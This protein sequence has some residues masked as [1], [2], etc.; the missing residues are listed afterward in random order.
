M[1][2]K[3][4]N[5]LLTVLALLLCSAYLAATRE[6]RKYPV[7]GREM[8]ANVTSLEDHRDALAHW[9]GKG[10]RNAVLM[11]IDAHDDM[12]KIP[13]WQMAHVKLACRQQE[14]ASGAT[15]KP[16][17]PLANGN[18]IHAAAKMGIIK[19]VIW[20]VPSSYDLFSDPANRLQGLLTSYGFSDEDIGTF[21]LGKGSFSG[22]VDGIPL[23]ICDS[24]SLP[25]LKEPILLSID[26]DFFP[27]MLDDYKL[28]ITD[29]LKQTFSDLSG[30]GYA[31]MDATVAYSVN[32][33][34][35]DSCRRWVG[36]LIIDAVRIPSLLSRPRLPERYVFLQRT[37]LL[38][39]MKRYRELLMKLPEVPPGE[40][41]PALLLYGAKAYQGMAKLDKA[42]H[43][44]EMACLRDNRYCGGLPEL[45]L[46][47]LEKGEISQAERFF[48]RGYE[49][50]P[51]MDNGQ[52]RLAMAL[53][54]AGRY[55]KA[56]DYFRVFRKCYGPFPVDFYLA[57]TCMLKGD[58]I[59]ARKYYDSGRE[60]L[61]GNPSAL[62]G[63][64][65]MATLAK[66]A[67]FYD[68]KEETKYALQ[69]RQL[70]QAK[71]GKESFS[72]EPLLY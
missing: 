40:T 38:M 22:T 68:S 69:I 11:N 46:S 10:F 25:D 28:T 23:A 49:L 53:K 32:G 45:G 41:D 3:I 42:F 6:Y 9:Y 60:E 7:L 54:K 31:I 43:Y 4:A 37:D 36:E 19:R 65:D 47:I 13:P 57:E 29:A 39:Q 64:G 62:N 58:D 61:V 59:S 56:I 51:E 15:R 72:T 55:D 33:G 34:Y 12:K 27:T 14:G 52:F 5:I 20:V 71:A 66:G 50:S 1:R 48:L 30:K 2:K 44:A 26:V 24:R 70:L 35:L 63:F 17:H 8:I 18:F 67:A 21:R 16:G